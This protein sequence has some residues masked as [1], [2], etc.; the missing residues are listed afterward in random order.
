MT[1][2]KHHNGHSSTKPES[3][4][5]LLGSITEALEYLDTAAHESSD[6]LRQML[7][8][9]YRHLRGLVQEVTPEVKKSLQDIQ[10]RASEMIPEM[11]DKAVTYVKGRAEA[12]DESVRTNPWT[13]IGTVSVACVAL[14]FFMGRRTLN[15]TESSSAT[16]TPVPATV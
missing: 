13:V 12:V 15:A 6:E 1:T 10:A 16:S 9:D 11:R 5:A 4:Q 3:T 2:K 14:G 7:M 8:Q